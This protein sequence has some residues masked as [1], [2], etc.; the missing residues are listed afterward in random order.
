MAAGPAPAAQPIRQG[1]TVTYAPVYN[2]QMTAEELE[3]AQA[4]DYERFNRLFDR[5]LRE[6]AA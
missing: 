4:R 5:R 3:E 6:D 1:H 2:T